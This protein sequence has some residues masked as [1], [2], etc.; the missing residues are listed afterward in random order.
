MYKGDANLLTFMHCAGAL[1]PKENSAELFYSLSVTRANRL[2]HFTLRA[3]TANETPDH[4]PNF[5]NDFGLA[6]KT[7]AVTH[8]IR[9]VRAGE[10]DVGSAE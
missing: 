2:P 1:R 5:V 6:L 8:K 10:G 4:L 7:V 3:C 9:R